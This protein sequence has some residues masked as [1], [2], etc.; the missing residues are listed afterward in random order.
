[1]KRDLREMM[2]ILLNL[3][4]PHPPFLKLYFLNKTYVQYYTT[5]DLFF[6]PILKVFP[7]LR[8]IF[9]TK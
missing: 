6:W 1:M 3:Y 5:S 9:L 2:G 7:D 8:V 4:I